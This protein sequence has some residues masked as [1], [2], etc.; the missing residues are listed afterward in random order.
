MNTPPLMPPNIA[1]PS[2]VSAQN[3]QRKKSL[4]NI[5]LYL[6]RENGQ[7]ECSETVLFKK[8]KR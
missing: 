1:T 4:P 5:K 2:S 7:T 6:W 8:E 3:D